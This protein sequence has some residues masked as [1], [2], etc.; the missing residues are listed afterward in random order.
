[1][2]AFLLLGKEC[3]AGVLKVPYLMAVATVEGRVLIIQGLSPME[4]SYFENDLIGQAFVDIYF[5]TNYTKGIY[6]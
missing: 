1:M 4:V 5:S 3:H 6:A 2:I